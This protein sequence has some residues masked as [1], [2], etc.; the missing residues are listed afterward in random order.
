M[1]TKTFYLDFIGTIVEQ[2]ENLA[3]KPRVNFG[4]AEVLKKLL[5]AGHKI[6]V[7][8][9]VVYDISE[10]FHSAYKFMKRPLNLNFELDTTNITFLNRKVTPSKFDLTQDEIFLDDHALG[11]PLKSCC[12]SYGYM[13]DWDVLDK[14]F[15][16]NK[17]Y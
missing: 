7:N 10:Y 3:S 2:Q 17:I 15:T 12:M 8:S 13:V 1:K 9:S 6:V 4:Y 5:L 16:E 14:L 11:I